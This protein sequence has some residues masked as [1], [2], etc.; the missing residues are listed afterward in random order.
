[1]ASDFGSKTALSVFKVIKDKL[2]Q[3]ILKDT[4]AQ[5]RDL[6][7]NLLTLFSMMAARH[8]GDG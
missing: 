7:A 3:I 2:G 4:N 8:A 5:V 6:A 1:M